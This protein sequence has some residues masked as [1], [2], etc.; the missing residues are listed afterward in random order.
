MNFPFSV[1][2][3]R[4]NGATTAKYS[5]QTTGNCI[6]QPHLH[7]LYL[8][9][10]QNLFVKCLKAPFPLPPTSV[11]QATLSHLDNPRSLLPDIPL[12]FLHF[13]NLF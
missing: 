13:S 3:L 6:I 10:S 2:L 7:I 8:L 12:P 1:L 5:E 9:D 4:V 11:T